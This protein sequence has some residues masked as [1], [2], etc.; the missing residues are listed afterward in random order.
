[1][2]YYTYFEVEVRDSDSNPISDDLDKAIF[3]KAKSLSERKLFSEIDDFDSYAE[4]A[5]REPLFTELFDSELKWYD[6]DRDMKNLSAEFPDLTFTVTGYGEKSLDI[7]RLWA[8]NGQTYRSEA[9]FTFQAPD[10]L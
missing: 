3:Q 10:W 1:M 9:E 7:W 2:G 4:S 8:R 6:C 5:D